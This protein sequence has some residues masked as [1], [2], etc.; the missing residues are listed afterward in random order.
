[1]S[2]FNY[3]PPDDLMRELVFFNIF[4]ELNLP[5][6]GPIEDAEVIKLY[7]PSPIPCLYVAPAENMPSTWWA[8]SPLCHRHC[9]WLEMRLRRSLTCTASARIP[10]S[11]WAALTQH[12]RTAGV[13]AVSMRLTSGCGNL[14]VASHTWVV[15]QLRQLKKG[16]KLTGM[17][18]M[19]VELRLVGGA[20]QNTNDSK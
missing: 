8:E 3:C 4:E 2:A 15:C 18:V 1:M 14:G 16:C 10:V 20:R 11:P 19:L 6:K 13:A 5:I 12:R 9:F 7:E 17:K